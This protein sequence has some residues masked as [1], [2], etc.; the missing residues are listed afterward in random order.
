VNLLAH[1]K[2]LVK[3]GI[4]A[5]LNPHFTAR[6]AVRDLFF[7]VAR[8]FTPSVVSN[9]GGI[10]YHVSTADRTVGREVFL[11]GGYDAPCIERIFRILRALG[12]QDFSAK[13]FVDIGANI[14]TSTLPAL[15]QYGFARAISFEPDATNFALL[16]QSIVDNGLEG[17][18]HPV[19]VALSDEEKEVL[20]ERCPVNHGDHR[21]RS[22]T[23]PSDSQDLMDENTRSVI[24]IS[25]T[26]FDSLVRRKVI[27]L[28]NV[29]LVWMDTEG[30]EGHVFKGALSLL[31]SD[32]PVVVEYWPYALQRA[33]GLELYEKLLQAHYPSMVDTRA[34]ADPD[35]PVLSP[36]SRLPELREHYRD[37]ALTDL[38]LLKRQ[39]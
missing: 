36:T 32:V 1:P 2:Q 25:A 28:D 38:L 17:R 14:G 26:T 13:T 39:P 20:F 34:D 33:G 23:A 6:P 29:G 12:Y 18:V 8:E 35:H 10:R 16:Q 3:R 22:R 30:H 31:E 9:V 19:R 4:Q 15:I 5:V 11:T 21:I 37:Y 24:P 27:P 7:L